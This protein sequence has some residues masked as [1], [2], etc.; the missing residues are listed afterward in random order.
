MSSAALY[1]ILSLVA[2]DRDAY[3]EA[4]SRGLCLF[5]RFVGLTQAGVES[6]LRGLTYKRLSHGRRIY[7]GR[8]VVFVGREKISLGADVA[9]YGFDYL[10]AEGQSGSISIGSG[11]RVDQFCALYGQGGL[12]IGAWCAIASGVKIYSQSNQYKHDQTQRILD[13]K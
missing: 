3:R 8:S 4:F 7:V 1:R 12:E 13:R 5:A 2:F 11:T 10:N 9:L 6:Y